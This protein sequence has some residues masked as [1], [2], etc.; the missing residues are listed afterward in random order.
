MRTI[1]SLIRYKD[2]VIYI[3]QM[4]VYVC[5]WKRMN[6]LQVVL[7]TAGHSM[8]LVWEGSSRGEFGLFLNQ[9]MCILD[10]KVPSKSF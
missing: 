7:H 1:P 5:V 2:V 4:Y 10:T 9:S 6:D 3:I 8:V